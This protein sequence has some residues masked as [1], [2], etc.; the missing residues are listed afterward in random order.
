MTSKGIDV[1]AIT[2]RLTDATTAREPVELILVLR[3]RVKQ[4]VRP[5][6]WRVRLEGGQVMSFDADSVA[7]VTPL[8]RRPG[9]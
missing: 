9:T 3:G 1:T 6:R 2:A 5:G 8:P 4:G 7:A